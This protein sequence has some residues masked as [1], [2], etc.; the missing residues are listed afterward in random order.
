MHEE[1]WLV[2]GSCLER[3]MSSLVVPGI[4]IFSFYSGVAAAALTGHSCLR[5]AARKAEACC[6]T[7][8]CPASQRRRGGWLVS[9]LVSCLIF[10]Q[11]E[12]VWFP[13]VSW[14]CSPRGINPEQRGAAS[15][16]TVQG[17]WCWSV[18]GCAR[19]TKTLLCLSK[20][21]FPFD[22]STAKSWP[23]FSSRLRICCRALE[24]PPVSLNSSLQSAPRR[25]VFNI[26]SEEQLSREN[27]TRIL[28]WLCIKF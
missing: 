21:T 14:Q 3:W 22:Q 28:Y 6:R 12:E 9:C 16:P 26:N 5:F 24:S 25:T 10:Y 19:L 4:E 23:S 7:L 2:A 20:V 1:A 13:G 11:I 15:H 27:H 8:A 17:C 18:L